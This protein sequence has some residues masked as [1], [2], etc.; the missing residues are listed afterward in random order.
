MGRA[1]CFR[2]TRRLLAEEQPAALPEP[3]L[4]VILGGL[5]GGQPQVVRRLRVLPEEIVQALIVEY[6]DQVPVIQAGALHRPVRD[7]E[8]QRADQ[9][10]IA[11]G[12]RTGA[13]NIPAVLGDFRLNQNNMHHLSIAP[14]GT[15]LT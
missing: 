13:G 12:G 14:F 10:Q 4:T 1:E 5:G 2:Q 9:M 6:P 7:V 8:A 3:G 11:A 15:C